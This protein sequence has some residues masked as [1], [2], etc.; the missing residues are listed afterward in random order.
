M[1]SCVCA[2]L[3]SH[4]WFF[5]TPWTVARQALLSMESST[6]EYWS[7]LPFPNPS[8]LSQSFSISLGIL[9]GAQSR[10]LT[11]PRSIRGGPSGGERQE[12]C[13]GFLVEDI[14]D[15]F[16]PDWYC[17]TSRARHIPHHGSRRGSLTGPQLKDH[18]DH[19][20]GL[21]A[22]NHFAGWGVW[23]SWECSSY[24]IW[25]VSHHPNE[26]E[27]LKS[28]RR[29]DSGGK[30]KK[31]IKQKSKELSEESKSQKMAGEQGR[32]KEKGII[33]CWSQQYC[34]P[35]TSWKT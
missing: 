24:R 19:S 14:E 1:C 23:L 25:I 7:V 32:S 20:D 22:E 27:W 26:M 34:L 8:S 30:K 31:T 29:T 16:I 35:G 28:G 11:W 21:L 10:H 13:F 6:Q 4:F 3:L 12:K 5:A 17:P 15:W 9:L 33:L 2:Q 18:L